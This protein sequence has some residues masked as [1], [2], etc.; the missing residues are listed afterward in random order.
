MTINI[1]QY[2]EALTNNE[3][4]FR[5]LSGFWPLN[6]GRGEPVFSVPGQRL[7]DFEI[8]DGETVMSLRC[9]LN[10]G[11]KA[12]D[13]LA[14]LAAKDAHLA[15]EFFTPWMLL[16]Q[17]IVLFDRAGN[18]VEVDVLVRPAEKGFPLEQFLREVA[19]D[20][21]LAG[22]ALDEVIKLGEWSRGVGREVASH[23]LLFGT[24]G[25]VRITG[26]SARG[27][28]ERIVARLKQLT[29]EQSDI[30]PIYEEV[31]RDES[32]GLVTVESEGRWSLLDH[33]GRSLTDE[34]YE[35][36]GEVCEGLILAQ[37]GGLC[38]FL[39]AAG[40]EAIPFIYDDAT[41]FVEGCAFVSLG[42][43]NFCIDGAGNRLAARG[44]GELET[45]LA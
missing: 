41:S 32:H 19:G 16:E 45:K 27:N 38:G 29:A 42:G 25:S 15:S 23:R 37:K 1:Q 10:G 20:E 11:V 35:W 30:E 31:A 7:V 44:V 4:R 26:F 28:V 8:T 3:G 17:E 2:I 33:T 9:P 36:I 18:P 24:D 39:D 13:K 5:T 14:V 43:E 12:A 6:D 22:V 34:H 21:Q 40:R